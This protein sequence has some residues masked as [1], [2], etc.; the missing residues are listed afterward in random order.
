[1]LLGHFILWDVDVLVLD[2]MN[3]VCWKL[4]G[5]LGLVW[6]MRLVCVTNYNGVV[7]ASVVWDY[8]HLSFSFYAFS[9]SNSSGLLFLSIVWDYTFAF[10]DSILKYILM[11]SLI[12]HQLS[13]I[14]YTALLISNALLSSLFIYRILRIRIIINSRPLNIQLY[15]ISIIWWYQILPAKLHNLL[16][17]GWFADVGI[18]AGKFAVLFD[19]LIVFGWI[20]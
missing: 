10:L 3:N 15:L 1:M 20:S 18:L 4:L 5:L 7:A 13:I 9:I 12:C 16:F 19:I 6:L 17:Q 8:L 14:L 11:I 2:L